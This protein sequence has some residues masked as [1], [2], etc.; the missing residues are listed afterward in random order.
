MKRALSVI[1]ALMFVFAVVQPAIVSKSAAAAVAVTS[2]N[3]NTSKIVWPVG[4][5]GTFK[6]TVYPSNAANR[7]VTWKSGNTKVATVDSSGKLT[8]KGYG[9]ATITCTSKNN[10]SAKATCF[11]TVG[12]GITSVKLN[13]AKLN[14]NVGKI[15]TFKATVFPNDAIRKDLIWKSSNPAVASISKRGLLVAKKAG[16]ATITCA[17]AFNSKA[18]ATCVVSVKTVIEDGVKDQWKVA[19]KDFFSD[20]SS[21]DSVYVNDFNRDGIPEVFISFWNGHN[22]SLFVTFIKDKGIS[23]LS[24][25]D[26]YYHGDKF[27]FDLNQ[28]V[29]MTRNNEDPNSIT[30]LEA[31]KYSLGANGFE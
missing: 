20:V 11:V 4:R 12:K 14:W 18:K 2:V 15:G 31:V 29:I 24:A 6:A 21:F 16:T 22:P 10:R 13:T 23:T 3:L 7:E 8:A 19:Y 25:G 5:T 28:K 17:S 1:L 27:Y 9:T 30:N 26:F